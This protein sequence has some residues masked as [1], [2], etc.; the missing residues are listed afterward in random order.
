MTLP[1]MPKATAVWLVENTA[2]TFEQI[3]VGACG[4][5]ETPPLLVRV[6]DLNHY[7]LFHTGDV[8][9]GALEHDLH[10]TRAVVQHPGMALRAA[11]GIIARSVGRPRLGTI[12]VR[13]GRYRQH[14]SQQGCGNPDSTIV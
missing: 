10:T 5:F 13:K 3:A 12:A 8:E 14:A 9:A 1:L 4:Q 11:C 6:R 7:P 2:L